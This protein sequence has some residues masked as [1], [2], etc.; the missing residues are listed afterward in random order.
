M[1]INTAYVDASFSRQHA[2]LNPPMDGPARDEQLRI[3]RE[4]HDVIG[5]SF[6]AISVQAAAAAHTLETRPRQAAAALRAI[7]TASAEALHEF[8][9]ILGVLRDVSDE[10]PQAVAPGLA[11]LDDLA[12]TMRRAGLATVVSVI[13]RPR[14]LAAE[15]DLA[16]Y[17]IVQESLA[18]VLHHAGP[19]RVSVFV[20]YE[21]DR[22]LVE[23][24][25]DGNGDGVR[26][27]AGRAHH[28][29]AGMRERAES[30]GGSLEAG[31]RRDGGFR[32]RAVLPVAGRP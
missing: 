1:A 23:V 5:Y 7:Q 6:A 8:R 25:D 12:D 32:V 24:V 14:P 10:R 29:I 13:G 17:R 19:A 11:R 30:L 4:L 27:E 31:A 3:A 15:V 9:A 20:V 26:V 18:N 21:R 16:A 28:G 22:L 2:G